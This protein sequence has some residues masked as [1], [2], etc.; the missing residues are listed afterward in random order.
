MANEEMTMTAVTLDAGD[1]DEVKGRHNHN[2][3]SSHRITAMYRAFYSNVAAL[4]LSDIQHV[5]VT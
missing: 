4:S 1:A 2:A 5:V 3:V